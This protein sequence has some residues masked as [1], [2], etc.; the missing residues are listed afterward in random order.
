M[1]SDATLAALDAP[2][3]TEAPSPGE[4]ARRKVLAAVWRAGARASFPGLV[5]WGR[6]PSESTPPVSALG[7][8][9]RGRPEAL[10]RALASYI[11]NARAFGRRVR[12]VVVDDSVEPAHRAQNRRGLDHL[13]RR[14]HVP[15]AYAGAE[16]RSAFIARLAQAS[17][18][19]H[20]VVAFGLANP[21]GFPMAA[22]SARNTLL[23]ETL[24]ELAIS[25]DDDTVCRIAPAPG[26]RD[27]LAVASGPGHTREFYPDNEAALAAAPFEPH[28]FFGLHERLLGRSVEGRVL[29]AAPE[30]LDL[31][32]MSRHLARRLGRGNHVRM[33][34]LGVAGHS[35][36][37]HWARYV[38]LRG[39]CRQ[40]LLSSEAS[41]RACLPSMQVIRASRRETI[42]D[43]ANCMG[44]NLGLDN[45]D[46]L[47]P[48][49]P[50]QRNEDGVFGWL[51]YRGSG[52]AC[53]G[54]LPWVLVHSP[55]P[56][57]PLTWADAGRVCAAD[58]VLSLFGEIAGPPTERPLPGGLPALG[59]RLAEIGALPAAE[60][61]ERLRLIR[62]RTLRGR[63]RRTENRLAEYHH[64]P[65]FWAEDVQRYAATLRA[66]LD[67]RDALADDLDCAEGASNA[68][69]AMGLLLR[70]FG[71][72]LDAWPT[73]LEA[74]RD[75]RARGIRVAVPLAG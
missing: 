52:D 46:G 3:N 55:T 37:G 38:S 44:I 13:R 21:C 35:G 54:S 14:F 47:P 74:T 43:G 32:S 65:S 16:E 19:R 63:L 57:P 11:E 18:V 59:R 72:L 7:I 29:A 61:H 40:R 36:V 4:L 48:F 41:Y 23:L 12:F 69:E 31:K 60:L 75:L 2:S 45:R 26:A 1:T 42:A 20:E 28:D 51:F 68:T 64:E 30:G 73:L 17:D 39:A 66:R 24:G 70:R 50:V 67:S 15:I 71:Q 49:A 53:L 33:T 8:P 58:F 62:T 6:G 34:A 9:T 25:V 10:V 56:R 27:G 22:G 5:R